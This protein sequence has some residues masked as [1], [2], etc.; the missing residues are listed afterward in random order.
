MKNIRGIVLLIVAISVSGIVNA[1]EKGFKIDDKTGVQYRFIKHNKKGSPYAGAEFA[2]VVI[3][4]TG[5]TVKGDKD[6]V[7][8]DTHAKGGDSAGALTIPLKSAFKGSLE[9]G[10]MMMMQGDSAEFKINADSLYIKAFH[11]DAQRIPH[12]ITSKTLFTF[13]IKLFNFETKDEMMAGRQAEVKRLT[14]KRDARKGQEGKDIATYLQKNHFDVKPDADS[15]FYLQIAKGTGA[16]VQEG[17]SLDI[18]Y[19]GMFLDGTVFDKSDRGVPPGTFKILYTKNVPL[20]QGW[21]KVL[22]QMNEGEKV[23][24]LLPSAMAYGVRGSGKIEPYTPLIFD[25]E[26]VRVKA[27]K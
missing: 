21:I 20:I 5:P 6:S 17:D 8:L 16:Q 26:V 18:K 27:T 14:A 3:L 13:T 25:M 1:Q 9:D 10:I 7:Y 11:V 19:T 24:V 23:R 22:A 2:R 12:F 4:W 15:I